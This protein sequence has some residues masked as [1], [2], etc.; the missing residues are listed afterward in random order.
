MKGSDNRKGDLSV[1][2]VRRQYDNEIEKDYSNHKV[3]DQS[4]KVMKV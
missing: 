2:T 1:S 3:L 4:D